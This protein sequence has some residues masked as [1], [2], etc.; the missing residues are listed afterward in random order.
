MIRERERNGLPGIPVFVLQLL[1]IVVAFSMFVVGTGE[2]YEAPPNG[3]LILTAIALFVVNLFTM[4]GH[5][6]VAPNSARV[7]Q[8]FGDY[9]G[10]AKVP[11]LRWAN[12]F[13]SKKRI[14]LRIRNFESSRL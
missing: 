11:G 10:T 2:P 3:W 8:L 12:P 9:V 7:L 6:I 4:A 1:V 13:Y 5:F 14:S